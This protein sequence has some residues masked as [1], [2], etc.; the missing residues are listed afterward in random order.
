MRKEIL[1]GGYTANPSDQTCPDG[2]LSI[3]TD[4][5][6]EYGTL[7][8]AFKPS[9][10]LELSQ[11]DR[12][13]F[14]HHTT[15]YKH[16]IVLNGVTLRWIDANDTKTVAMIKSFGSGTTVHSVNA[17]GNTLVVL[18]T[19]GMYYFLFKPE[20][21]F[22]LFLGNHIPEV[23]IAFS[24]Q[25]EWK[26]SDKFNAEVGGKRLSMKYADDQTKDAFVVPFYDGDTLGGV[27]NS[28]AV[29]NRVMG[30]ANKFI[31]DNATNKGRFMYPFLV[32]YALRLYDGSCTMLS[33]PVLMPC[34]TGCSPIPVVTNWNWNDNNYFK[35]WELILLAPVFDLVYRVVD[36]AAID[37]IKNW[38]DIVASVD[39]FI[40]K[41]VYT[42]DINGKITKNDYIS[43]I[44]CSVYGKDITPISTGGSGGGYG[45]T[46]AATR[47][48][49]LVYE[50]N[51]DKGVRIGFI[52]PLP[53]KS[54]DAVES[55]I[56]EASSFFFLKS[57]KIDEL[58]TILTKV[59]VKSDYLQSLVNR[60]TLKD[61]YDSHDLLM[62]KYS[63]TYNSRLNLTGIS[64]KLFQGFRPDTMSMYMSSGHV[65]S[66]V[67][68][69]IKQDG[70]DLVVHTKATTTTY[71]DIFYFYYPNANAYKAVVH[72]DGS[73]IEYPLSGHPSLNGAYYFKGLATPSTTVS[74]APG[75]SDDCVVLQLSKLY[76]SQVNNA[77]YFP[78][79]GIKTV[80]TGVIMA[81]SSAARA[82]SMGQF[83]AFPLYCFSTDGVWAMKVENDGFFKPA[84]PITRDVCLS[85]ESI[86]QIDTAVLFVT[87]RGIMVIEGSETK[88]ISDSID[89]KVVF[90][91]T[92]LPGLEKL[93]EKEGVDK[94]KLTFAPF[95]QYAAGCR[96][97]YDYIHQ[98]II[99][100]NPNYAYSYIFSMKDKS[101]TM[102]LFSAYRPVN[103]YPNA[104]A[105]LD[106]GNLVSFSAP[107]TKSEDS[108]KSVVVTRPFKLDLPFDLKTVN[109]IIQ[110][111]LFRHG[112]VKQALY[113]SRD[114]FNWFLVWSSVD[115]YL[116][117]FSGSPYK[118]FR[119]ALVCDLQATE[120]L[121]G[122]SVQFTP[123][124]TDRPR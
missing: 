98:R 11:G 46:N 77:F 71:G 82:L 30:K 6:H 31:A 42:Y 61:D 110:R 56:E 65:L 66:D 75:E 24:L 27:P 53:A 87:A 25:W 109:T 72:S 92:M 63:F 124:M 94:S 20:K 59:D 104:L 103:D 10:I 45:I 88:C 3:A 49:N 108:V 50:K 5:V 81:I 80:G 15:L 84:Q 101:W 44:N 7:G 97:S 33:A 116:R 40:T 36:S 90:D 117:G 76:T 85:V 9:T 54:A 41:P 4:L 105:Q 69:Y 96:M 111:G 70:R 38:K 121:S 120:N 58:S 35:G 86:L 1:Y 118:Y 13:V 22:Y 18:T 89:S 74:S 60:E 39:I 55:E 8:P 67:W 43:S 91:P 19:E 113:G 21:N 112:H 93:L 64:K 16:Y 68:V 29:S 51:A 122:C 52:T 34:V 100:F 114:G 47:A 26:Q 2:D 57:I 123:R 14:V 102:M 28:E 95:L 32:R 79:A 17:V 99:V 73:Y 107:D 23:P 62:P 12:V 106:N 78:V 37:E 119:L 83:G 48:K 115:E